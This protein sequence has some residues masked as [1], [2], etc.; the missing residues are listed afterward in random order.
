MRKWALS[1]EIVLKSCH[2][3]FRQRSVIQNLTVCVFVVVWLISQSHQCQRPVETV[4][5]SSASDRKSSATARKSKTHCSH[6]NNHLS[7]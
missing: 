5:S 3:V 4:A 1:G 6:G 7:V 2:S